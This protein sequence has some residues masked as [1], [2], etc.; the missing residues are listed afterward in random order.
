MSTSKASAKNN[1]KRKFECA[2]KHIYT[3]T[4]THIHIHA[5]FVQGRELCDGAAHHSTVAKVKDM[6]R[7]EKTPQK[8]QQK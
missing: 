6:K 1:N 4:F 3:N 7:R 5:L 8:Q 2:N